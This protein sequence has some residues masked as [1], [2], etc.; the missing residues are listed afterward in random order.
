MGNEGKIGTFI[1]QDGV[2]NLRSDENNSMRD[3]GRQARVIRRLVV[4]IFSAK[5][6]S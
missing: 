3:P 2:G 1:Y 6:G 5:N 4:E